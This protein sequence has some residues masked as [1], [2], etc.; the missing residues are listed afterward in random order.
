MVARSPAPVCPRVIEATPAAGDHQGPP[1]RPSSTLA[2]TE[3]PTPFRQVDAYWA[4]AP[5][6]STSPDVRQAQ[7]HRFQVDDVVQDY[8]QA[9]PASQ[10]CAALIREPGDTFARA[11][12][13]TSQESQSHGY[14]RR[15][16]A[17][18]RYP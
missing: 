2:P 15:W 12:W 1:H 5:V 8:S 17:G 7:P 14:D 18:P 13:N 6:S 16:D 4:V 3:H 11:Y 9:T 10:T